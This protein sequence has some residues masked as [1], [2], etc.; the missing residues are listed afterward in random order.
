MKDLSQHT[1]ISPAGRAKN[2]E[3]FMGDLHSNPEAQK[4]LN[5]WQMSFE[6]TL[7]KMTG[8]SLPAECK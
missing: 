1:R 5:Q 2:L 6:K 3:D 7:L 4:E 8:R